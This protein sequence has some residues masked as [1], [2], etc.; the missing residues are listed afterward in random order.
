[1]GR[2]REEC[3]RLEAAAWGDAERERLEGD[4]EA[5]LGKA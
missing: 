2:L 3:D 4:L 1:M 5:A